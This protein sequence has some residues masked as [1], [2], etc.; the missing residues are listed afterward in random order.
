MRI[1]SQPLGKILY[2][3][4]GS[5]M[6]PGQIKTRCLSPEVRTVARLIDHR[7]AFFGTSTVWDGALET[8]VP[9]PGRDVWGVLYALSALDADSLDAWQDARFDGTG[10]YFHSPVTVIDVQGERHEALLY[11]KDMLGAPRKPSHEYLDHI[12]RGAMARGLPPRY[13]EY[14]GALAAKKATYPVPIPRRGEGGVLRSTT[15]VDCGS[16]LDQS[17]L[18]AAAAGQE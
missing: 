16:L 6:N 5:N 3:A 4:Y 9:S 2:F 11:K 14:L 18:S 10:A 1:A 17:P 7:L 12:V 8:V 15:C 13:V